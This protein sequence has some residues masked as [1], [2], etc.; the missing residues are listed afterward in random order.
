MPKGGS[1]ADVVAIGLIV[2]AGLAALAAAAQGWALRQTK[3]AERAL[4]ALAGL[5]LV[6]PGLLQPV[7]RGAAG[8]E[9][10]YPALVGLAIAAAILLKQK[11]APGPPA[12]ETSRH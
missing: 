7:F 11:L 2:A 3:G 10:P 6:F 5:L 9:L 1:I 12:Q 4:L 8:F